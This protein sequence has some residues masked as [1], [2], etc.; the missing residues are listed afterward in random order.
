MI[1]KD[2]MQLA[3]LD[4]RM[5]KKR[6]L[7]WN[8]KKNGILNTDGNKKLEEFE[9]GTRKNDMGRLNNGYDS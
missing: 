3:E 2:K 4:A 8:D 9:D 7:L 1:F 5:N 6:K